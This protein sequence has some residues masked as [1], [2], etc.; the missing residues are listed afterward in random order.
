M[1]TTQHQINKQ[2]KKKLEEDLRRYFSKEVTQ[3]RHMKNAQKHFL[4]GNCKS[5]PRWDAIPHLLEWLSFQKP[6]NNKCGEDVEKIKLW[7]TVGVIVNW[8]HHYGKYY[9]CSSKS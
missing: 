8:Y 2:L 5:K 6:T 7:C 9:G 1:Q 3:N 4:S